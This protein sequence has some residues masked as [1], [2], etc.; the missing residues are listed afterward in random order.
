MK[1]PFWNGA[2]GNEGFDNVTRTEEG[3]QPYLVISLSESKPSNPISDSGRSKAI[4]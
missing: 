4:A 3:G 2:L 1:A